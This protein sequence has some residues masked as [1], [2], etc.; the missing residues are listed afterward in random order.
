VPESFRLVRD[1]KFIEDFT[2]GQAD[3]NI[4]TAA[5]DIDADTQFE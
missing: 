3:G 5:A 1:R 2:T 4:V